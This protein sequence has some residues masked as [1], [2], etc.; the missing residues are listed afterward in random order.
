MH[1]VKDGNFLRLKL[2]FLPVFFCLTEILIDTL[3]KGLILE[4]AF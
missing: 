1:L 4:V 2:D 3:V